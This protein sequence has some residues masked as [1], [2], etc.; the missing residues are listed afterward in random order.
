MGAVVRRDR[1]DFEW[2][3]ARA[4]TKFP[5]WEWALASKDDGFSWVLFGMRGLYKNA[6]FLSHAPS[7]TIPAFNLNDVVRK[8][9]FKNCDKLISKI[10]DSEPPRPRQQFPT[11]TEAAMREADAALS[12]PTL[13]PAETEK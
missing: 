4:K 11:P 9:R 13:P 2:V 8:E 7:D 6:V 12:T 5:D 10:I 3:L 1:F